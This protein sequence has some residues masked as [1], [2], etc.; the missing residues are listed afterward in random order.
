MPIKFR[1]PSIKVDKYPDNSRL[2]TISSSINFFLFSIKS[3]DSIDCNRLLTLSIAN[4]RQWHTRLRLVCH[5]L[6]E[7]PRARSSL[8]TEP[9]THRISRDWPS[10]RTYAST[11]CTGGVGETIKRKGGVSW[12]IHI[13]YIG[14]SQYGQLIAVKN[15]IATDQYPMTI[16]WGHVSTHRGNVIFLEA[17]RQ[18]VNRPFYICVLSALA[19]E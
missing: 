6:T 5:R 4:V 7:L 8:A 19:F 9:H 10:V 12:Q 1:I 11:D 14:H 13:F 16:S 15:R 17:V 3:I 18:P 2:V